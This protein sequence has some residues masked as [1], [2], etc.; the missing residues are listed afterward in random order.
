MWKGNVHAQ[1][2][3]SHDPKLEL[4]NVF[5]YWNELASKNSFNHTFSHDKKIFSRLYTKWT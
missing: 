2:I 1:K 4:F 3:I 5:F